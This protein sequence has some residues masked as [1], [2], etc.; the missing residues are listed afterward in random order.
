M[1]LLLGLYVLGEELLDG[2]YVLGLVLLEDTRDLLEL[3]EFAGGVVYFVVLVLVRTVPLVDVLVLFPTVVFE[4]VLELVLTP[5]PLVGDVL[6]VVER[7]EL[8]ICELGEPAE[9]LATVLEGLTL[10]FEATVP[11]E[12]PLPLTA[13][14]SFV[15][16]E[17]TPAPDLVVPELPT[18]GLVSPFI[19]AI[20]SEGLPVYISD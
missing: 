13:L 16:P 12:D 19:D 2:V 14:P 8:L 15:E 1:L 10:P 5:A 6:T 9:L 3:L 11:L 18:L 17:E 20:L 7:G 4:L